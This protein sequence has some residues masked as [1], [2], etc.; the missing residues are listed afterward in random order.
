MKTGLNLLQMH[1][2]E[3]VQSV[4]EKRVWYSHYFYDPSKL[5]TV[6]FD[7]SYCANCFRYMNMYM[8]IS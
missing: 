3:H 4:K 6:L 5:Y 7:M 8:Y 1:E 2:V